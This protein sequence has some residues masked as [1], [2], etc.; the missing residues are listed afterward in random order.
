GAQ[1]KDAAVI[2]QRPGLIAFRT[3]A[4]LP[5]KNGLTVAAAFPKGVVTAPTQAQQTDA[6]ANDNT[7]LLVAALGM[8]IVFGYY[9]YAWRRAGRDPARG[10]IIPLFGPPN[11]MS[12]AAV[13]YVRRM[14]FDDR[15]F[16]AA[17][18]DLAV[19]GRLK[20]NETGKVMSI[21][22][23]PGGKEIAQPEVV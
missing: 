15:T 17:V 16:T 21:E 13:R 18:V 2:E 11:N 22:K 6:W 19:H 7:P 12:A 14:D 4:P 1:G 8:L 3:T 23:Q 10:T 20:L 9:F 5:P